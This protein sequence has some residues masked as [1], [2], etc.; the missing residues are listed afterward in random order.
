MLD[1]YAFLINYHNDTEYLGKKYFCG[2]GLQFFYTLKFFGIGN[3][4]RIHATK[5]IF[6]YGAYQRS[7]IT[8]CMLENKN[9][10]V[11][12]KPCNFVACEENKI[13]ML[14]R[15]KFTVNMHTQILNTSS[16]RCKKVSRNILKVYHISNFT[17]V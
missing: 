11:R 1:V 17:T 16:S 12:I 9:V 4:N 10:S 3:R 7:I 6:K 14:M 13:N 15:I 5:N 8:L 2:K